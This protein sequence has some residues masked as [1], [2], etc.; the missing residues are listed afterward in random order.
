MVNVR[1]TVGANAAG[2]SPIQ[3]ISTG[4]YIHSVFCYVSGANPHGRTYAIVW[5]I[6]RDSVPISVL[7]GGHVVPRAP[8]PYPAVQVPDGIGIRLDVT[9]G[10]AGSVTV[11]CRVHTSRDIPGGAGGIFYES[12]GS[13]DGEHRSVLTTPAGAGAE[14]VQ[15]LPGNV[16]WKYKSGKFRLITSAAAATR[17]PSLVFDDGAQ[18]LSQAFDT[19]GQTLSLT[20]DYVW[21]V[22]I[23]ERASLG[24]GTTH[25]IPVPDMTLSGG[26]RWRT[27]T[28]NLQG[29]D[30]WL[31]GQV[32]VD[33][34][35]I[36]SPGNLVLI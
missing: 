1:V 31:L 11:L 35:A 34:W 15:V 36:P 33:E 16:L 7:W 10:S 26:A 28:T 8:G 32:E 30:Q 24:V 29:A 23:S 3:R 4:E 9:Q 19:I 5:L 13:G 6:S 25:A 22:G 2:Q 12:P 18:V 14:M 17:I 21:S 27:V 20:H